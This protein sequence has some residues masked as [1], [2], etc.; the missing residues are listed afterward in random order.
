MMRKKAELVHVN[1]TDNQKHSLRS[2]WDPSKMPRL[3]LWL[4][5]SHGYST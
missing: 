3:H 4:N 5:H 1:L 2:N